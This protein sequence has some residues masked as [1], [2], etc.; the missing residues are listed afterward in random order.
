MTRQPPQ[1]STLGIHN[2]HLSFTFTIRYENDLAPVR[3]PVRRQIRGRIVREIPLASFGIR[4]Q[5]SLLP[6]RSD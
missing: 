4:S 5:I 2:P 1:G 3:K 6:V